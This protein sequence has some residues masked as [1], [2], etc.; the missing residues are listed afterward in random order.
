M[1]IP[2]DLYFADTQ[3]PTTQTIDAANPQRIRLNAPWLILYKVSRQGL[4]EVVPQAHQE[5]RQPAELKP[6]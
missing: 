1:I 3:D 5:G 2:C 4:P 6:A